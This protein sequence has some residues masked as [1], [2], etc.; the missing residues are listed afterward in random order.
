MYQKYSKWIMAILLFT[1][2][3]CRNTELEHPA[4]KQFVISDSL[5]KTL[6]ID[7]VQ[8]LPVVYRLTLSGQVTFN[9]NKVARIFPLVSGN[10]SGVTVQEGDFVSKGQLLGTI[11]STQMADYGNEVV[12]AKTNLMMAKRNLEASEKMAESGL[13]SEKDLLAVRKEYEQAEAQLKRALEILNINGGDMQGAYSLRSPISGFVI[14]K[15][16]DNQMTI[17]EDNNEELFKIAE[18]DEVWVVANVY[19]SDIDRVHQGDV[20]EITTLS[21]PDKVFT[22]RIEQTLHVLDEHNKVMKVRV[23]MKNPNYLLKPRMFA[24][25]NVVKETAEHALCV[26]SSAIVFEDNQ[27]F[28]LIYKSEHEIRIRPIEIIS[29][30]IDRTYIS[31]DLQQGDKVISSDVILWFNALNS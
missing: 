7:T 20:V 25:V 4:Q 29:R 3:N 23:A 2:S 24:G 19:E 26:P 14:D 9:E 27:H 31:G 28:V 6:K 8:L 12:Q 11:R 18:L 30:D 10:L 15:K 22:G 16:V 13:I 1:L 5:M 21:Y 17:R